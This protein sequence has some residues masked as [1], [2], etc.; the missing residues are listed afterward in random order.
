MTTAGGCVLATFVPALPTGPAQ[1]AHTNPEP[2]SAQGCRRI[3][4]ILGLLR[5]LIA[6]GKDLAEKLRQNAGTPAFAHL[7]RPFGTTDLAA[8][9][10]S[11]IRGVGLAAALHERLASRAAHGRDLTPSPLRLPSLR[12]PGTS[13]PRPRRA[14]PEAAPDAL[15]LPTPEEIAALLRRRPLGALIVDICHDLGITPGDVKPALW[16]E[17]L[18]A[19]IEY[20]GSLGTYFT[21]TMDRLLVTRQGRHRATP[22]PMAASCPPAPPALATGP[23]LNAA[24]LAGLGPAIA[25]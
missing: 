3:G 13:R 23:P 24:V 20:G 9:F 21:G 6:Y 10:R 18:D 19:I 1:P 2:A 25:A 8:I 16:R 15:A 4:R 14:R 12:S 22:P 5:S 11:I 17:L 7:A